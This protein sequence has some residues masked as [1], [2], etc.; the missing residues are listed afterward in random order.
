MEQIL[1]SQEKNQAFLKF[2]LL[3]AVTIALVF[4]ATYY[5]YKV[6]VK[7]NE[8][9]HSQIDIKQIAEA[10]QQKFVDKMNEAVI[11]LDQLSENNADSQLINSKLGALLGA[12]HEL[13]GDEKTLYG[14]MNKAIVVKFSELKDA[15]KDINDFTRMIGNQKK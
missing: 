11:L 8:W 4:L 3:F 1:N 15:R 5:N 13:E 7:E 9:L 2:L 6:P 14:K 12:M 10:N